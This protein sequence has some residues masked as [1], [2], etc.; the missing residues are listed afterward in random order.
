VTDADAFIPDLLPNSTTSINRATQVP[1]AIAVADNAS[2][3]SG[4]AATKANFIASL[5]LQPGEL[6]EVQAAFKSGDAAASGAAPGESFLN[7]LRQFQGAPIASSL[8]PLSAFADVSPTDL[9]VFGERLRTVRQQTVQRLQASDPTGTSSELGAGL[10]A[11]NAANVGSQAL[12]SNLQTSPV[13]ML[14]LE[15]LEMTP[16][17]IERGGLIATIPLAPKERTFVVSKEWSVTTQEFTSIVTDALD[18]FSETG[19]T[20]NTQMTQATTAQVAHNNQFNV[21][22]SASG[23]IGFV[24]G[25]VSTTFGSQDSNSQ[26]AAQSRQ[27]SI[28]TTRMASSR[29]RQSHKT[30]IS[31][32]TV[33]G[34]SEATTRKIENPSDT[35]AM[36]IDYYSMMRKWYVALYRYGLRMTYDVTVPEPG[37]MLRVPYALIDAYQKQLSQEFS[38]P[39]T[40][41]DITTAIKPGDK[42][43]YYLVLADKYS[44]DVPPPPSPDSIVLNVSAGFNHNN[45]AP[46]ASTFTV[47]D[48][49]WISEIL[50]TGAHVAESPWTAPFFVDF[51][52]VKITPSTPPGFDLC[53]GNSF[54]WHQSGAQGL[55]LFYV[56]DKDTTAGT[57][58]FN[59]VCVPTDTAMAQWQGAV[60][61]AVYNGAQ[62]QFYAQQAAVSAKITALQV[63][64][65]NVDTLTLRREENDE[66][67]RCVLKWL[68]GP[69]FN[70]AFMPPAVVGAYVAAAI[71]AASQNIANDPAF[72]AQSYLDYGIDFLDN[73]TTFPKTQWSILS[74]QEQVINFIN[75]AIEWENVTFFTYSYFWDYPLCWDFI[76]QIQHDDKTRQAFLRAGSARVV[77]TVRK[78]WETAWTYFVLK[79]ELPPPDVPQLAHPYM[80]IA[81]QIAAYD[82][83]NYPG[84]PPANPDGGGLVDDDTPQT[85]TTCE[86]NI[87]PGPTPATP[88]A[89]PVDDATDFVVGATAIIDNW[90]AQ[91]DATT[92]VGPG[93]PGIGAQES[94]TITAVSASPA[95][96][97]VTGMQYSHFGPFPVVQ[98]GA[99][100]VL[101]GEWFEYTPTSGTDIDVTLNPTGP[102]A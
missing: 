71:E 48:G 86:T 80:T 47:P 95:T 59:V 11:L 58:S 72:G 6:E 68:L 41:S 85:G 32:T 31:T 65:A 88:V 44:V 97:T 56:N 43:P 13:G 40:H 89:I 18:N 33:T 49:Y 27:Q 17:G 7:L 79:G 93:G 90:D 84:I 98:S 102:I 3:P 74:N 70:F 78:G 8:P 91:I 26:T 52:G 19:V 83:T 9:T 45:V 76:R 81:Q 24:S 62:S 94:V 23:G 36:R 50:F 61:S 55:T 29:V 12:A 34:T 30:S 82:D 60:W 66:I 51:A 87:Q 54:L 14:N 99:K 28:Q 2:E 77:L 63:A 100:G 64:I 67:M 22:A 39:Y 57:L 96:I 10:I 92:Q 42:E 101:I 25:S 75:Q 35:N 38:F 69:Q 21:T 15:R 53:Q 16:A 73:Q 46:V 1:L 20:E 4:R 37:A 5:Q